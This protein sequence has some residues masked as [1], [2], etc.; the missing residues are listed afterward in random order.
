[1]GL[2]QS[3]ISEFQMK[4]SA[5]G[6]N[7]KDKAKKPQLSCSISDLDP[8]NSNEFA[9]NMKL[10]FSSIVQQ[11]SGSSTINKDQ[12][13]NNPITDCRKRDVNDQYDS[14]AEA[15]NISSQL[16]IHLLKPI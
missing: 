10:H 8:H 6:G 1:M 2:S 11:K 13:H 16:G 3:Q 14:T 5:V 15:K 4:F 12:N 7:S 9:G